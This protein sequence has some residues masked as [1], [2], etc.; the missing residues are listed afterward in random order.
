MK[1]S[2]KFLALAVATVL[3]SCSTTVSTYTSRTNTVTNRNIDVRNSTVDIKADFS[4]RITGEC[5]FKAITALEAKKAAE[6]D[7]I[8]RNNIDVL[9]DPIYQVS[10][11]SGGFKAK[12]TGYAGTYVNQRTLIDEI[13][14]FKDVDIADVEK[15]AASKNPELLIE[16]KKAQKEA[17]N[18]S[19]TN[20]FA[21]A[22][23]VPALTSSKNKK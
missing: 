17:D 7:A 5:N 21:P 14:Q 13:N 1:T 15:Y 4:K 11:Y 9:V 19:V 16:L 20:N 23:E 22:K 12:V 2:I 3:T 6:Y 10:S 8:V 18:I